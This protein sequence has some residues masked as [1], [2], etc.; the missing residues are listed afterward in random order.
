M[1]DKMY[2]YYKREIMST[3]SY[4][5]AIRTSNEIGSMFIIGYDRETCVPNG[6]GNMSTTRK[7]Q[8]NT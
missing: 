8:G 3:S 1:Y 2:Q 5:S 6:T 7:Q 4:D